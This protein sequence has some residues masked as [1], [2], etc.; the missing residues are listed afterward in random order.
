MPA[1]LASQKNGKLGPCNLTTVYFRGV[2]HLSVHPLAAR[3]WN[4]MAFQCWAETGYSLSTTGAYRS[5]DAQVTL[6]NQR[7]S[8]VYNPLTCTLT[9][10]TWNGKKYWLKRGQAACSTPGDSNHGW[11][12]AIDSAIYDGARVVGITSNAK[13]WAWIQAHA[14]EFGWSWEGAAPGKPGWEPWHL[15]YVRAENIPQRVKDVEALTGAAA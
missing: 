1:D 10:R 14:V 8:A 6:F 2:G 9:T 3:A 4:A 7:M 5:Y 12:I 13:V 15:R 11:G